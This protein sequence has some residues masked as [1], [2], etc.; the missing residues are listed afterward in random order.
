MSN[1]SLWLEEDTT[2]SVK[3]SRAIEVSLIVGGMLLIAAHQ[4]HPPFT[5]RSECGTDPWDFLH[6]GEI[7]EGSSL[8][9]VVE[10]H[11]SNARYQPDGWVELR[12]GGA[13]IDVQFRPVR[14]GES[15][16]YQVL[17]IGGVAMP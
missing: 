5:S 3:V 11:C 1:G 15:T 13:R 16:Y 6:I 4:P 10:A 8:A 2:F 14:I 7:M 12:Y 17:S 9:F